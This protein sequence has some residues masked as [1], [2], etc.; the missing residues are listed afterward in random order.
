MGTDRMRRM[1][2]CAVCALGLSTAVAEARPVPRSALAARLAEGPEVIGIVHWGLNTYTDREWGYGDEDPKRL[3]PDAFDA[4][5]IV[6]AC[7]AGGLGGL[8][9]VAK[10]HDGFCLWPTK[11]TGHNI[12][13]APFR[14]GKGDYVKEMSDAC[15]RAGLKFG[16]YCSPWDR[17]AADYGSPSYVEKYHAQ[18]KELLDG[19]YGEVFEMWFDGANGGDGYYGGAREKRRIPYGYYRF[20]EVFAFVRAFQPG[21]CIFAGEEDSSD[22]RWPGNE[23]GI[24]DPDSRATCDGVFG[25]V[26]QPDGHLGYGNPGYAAQIN[27]GSPTGT[28]FRVCES[29]FPLRPGWF[30]HAKERGQTKNAAYLMQRYLNTVGNGGTMNLGV[31]PDRRGRLDDED[32]R[33]LKGFGDLRR[34][35]FARPVTSGLAN[36]VVLREDIAKGERITGWTVTADGRPLASG[37]VVGNKRIR[38]LPETVD[39][40][41]IRVAAE[42]GELKSVEYYRADPELVKLVRDAT[43]ESGE[44]DTAK[45]MTGAV[46]RVSR[47]VALGEEI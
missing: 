4:D 14:N 20:D 10:H 25:L 2:V 32:V 11:T 28:F 17:N 36:V 45:W 41:R 30:Y 24:L 33:A 1:R 27:T 39:V 35:F 19:R 37:K 3:A 22:F 7:K 23:R 34:A 13:K 29:D 21:V 6:A 16:V 42:G 40:S 12:S 9:I 15:R 26:P 47:G 43:T 5:Q 31:A 8:V 44:T 18:V 38:I 46:S